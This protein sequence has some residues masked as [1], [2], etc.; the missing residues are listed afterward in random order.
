MGS[1][2]GWHIHYVLNTRDSPS[3]I[4]K[5]KKTPLGWGESPFCL[6]FTYSQLCAF[7]VQPEVLVVTNLFGVFSLSQL[8]R[9]LFPLG[10][11]KKRFSTLCPGLCFTTLHHAFVRVDKVIFGDWWL[12]VCPDRQ[13]ES[14]WVCVFLNYIQSL[15]TFHLKDNV[16]KKDARDNKRVSAQLKG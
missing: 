2:P 13:C 12:S 10:W 8:F 5:L 6:I 15:S 11:H 9:P 3:V 7:L 16:N 1:L 14:S 4:F